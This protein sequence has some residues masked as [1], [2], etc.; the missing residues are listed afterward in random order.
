MKSA[1][2]FIQIHSAEMSDTRKMEQEKSDV[3]H[4]IQQ[5]TNIRKLIIF[6]AALFVCRFIVSKIK[7]LPSYFSAVALH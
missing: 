6:H 3:N 2:Y 5:H 1:S 7:V 4:S